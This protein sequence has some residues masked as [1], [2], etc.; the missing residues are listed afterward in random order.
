VIKRPRWILNHDRIRICEGSRI[1]R[2]AKLEAFDSH[3]G[4][5]LDGHI[6]IGDDVYTGILA[7]M[8]FVKGEN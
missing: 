4:G 3:A 8:S 1:L 2:H 7:S 6:V 5:Q